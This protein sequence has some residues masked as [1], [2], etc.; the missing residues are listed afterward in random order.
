MLFR[1]RPSGTLASNPQTAG[2]LLASVPDGR[3]AAC[4]ADLKSRGYAHAAII[5][6][7][8]PAGNHLEPV[9][10]YRNGHR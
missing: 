6:A 2:G 9:T 3:A 8:M 4:L 10:V 7:V 1:S 5:G